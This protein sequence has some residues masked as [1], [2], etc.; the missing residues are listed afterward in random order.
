MALP[1]KPTGPADGDGWGSMRLPY[2]PDRGGGF[3]TVVHAGTRITAQFYAAKMELI[4]LLNEELLADIKDDVPPE[5]QGWRSPDDLIPLLSNPLQQTENLRRTVWAIN[6]AFRSAAALA[7]PGE[8]VP[9][10][11]NSKRRIGIRLQ[12]PFHLDQPEDGLPS[13]AP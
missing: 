11:I 6:R 12:W 10:L 2:G 5:A 8:Q 4:L 7:L 9:R 3:V 13:L 1:K